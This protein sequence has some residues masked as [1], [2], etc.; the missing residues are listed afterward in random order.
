[1]TFALNFTEQ[2]W[3]RIENDWTAW[4]AGELDRPIVVIDNPAY[5]RLPQELNEEFQLEKS[6]GEVL[7]YYQSRLE[8][9]QIFGDAW[10]RWWP[11]L[12]AGVVAAFLGAELH[13]SPEVETIWFELSNSSMAGAE[14]LTFDPKNIWWKRVMTLTEAAVNFW[15]DRIC[16]GFT[17]LGGNLDILSSLQTS[18]TLLFNLYD[19]PD[20]VKQI[21]SEITHHWLRYYVDLVTTIQ[22]T[23]RGTTPWASIWA[24][25]RCYMLQSDFSAMIS[26]RMFEMFVLPDLATC[27]EKI[28]YAFY[29][30]DGKGQIN[31]LDLLLSLEE[32][33][34]IQWIPGEGQP[35]PSSWLS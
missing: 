31:Y 34:G 15:G 16:V 5:S 3:Q 19:D 23:G 28:G 29:H 27:C 22:K 17:D 8:T 6:I 7:E 14:S 12:G 10:P 20:T 4:W 30:L 11:F 13:C 33:A 35:P 32:L 24:P 2:D 26:P 9:K 1:M 18:Q 21:S 25:G